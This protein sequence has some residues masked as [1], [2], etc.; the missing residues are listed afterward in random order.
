MLSSR[1]F[2]SAAGLGLAS[3]A[4]ALYF[5]YVEG[6]PPCGLCMWQRY[7]LGTGIAGAVLAALTTGGARLL[8]GLVAVLGFLWEAGVAIYHTGVERLWWDGPQACSGG[9][10]AVTFDPKAMAEAVASKPPPA[11]N[12]I[13]WDLFGL[14]MANYNVALAAFM[15]LLCLAGVRALR[16]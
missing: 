4:G 1:Y 15:A 16:G 8:F 7:A 6:L 3:F 11:C 14:S 9:S 12:E 2:T 5:Q 10:L 13:P